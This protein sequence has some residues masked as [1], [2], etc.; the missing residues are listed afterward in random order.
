MKEENEKSKYSYYL[1]TGKDRNGKRFRLRYVDAFWAFSINLWKGSV[2][3]V[4]D[5]GKRVL[6]NRV[7]N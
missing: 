1:V 4:L 3:G 7:S 6:L 5:S 2:W